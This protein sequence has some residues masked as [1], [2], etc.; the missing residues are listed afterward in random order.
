MA[1]RQSLNTPLQP[2]VWRRDPLQ[3]DHSGARFMQNKMVLGAIARPIPTKRDLKAQLPTRYNLYACWIA[4][5][6]PAKG[7]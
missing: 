4:R 5:P 7:N 1:F 6:I 3:K 2:R